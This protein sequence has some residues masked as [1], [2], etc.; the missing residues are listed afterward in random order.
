MVEIEIDV[1]KSLEENASEYF[2][3]AKKAKKK[4]EGA[5]KAY[6]LALKKKETLEKKRDEE[7]EKH[8]ESLKKE[9]IRK[10]EWYERFRWFFTSEGFLVIGGRDAT[11]NEIIIK[12]HTEKNDIV[13][14]TDMA[15]SPFFVIKADSAE[16]KEIGKQSLLE[17]ARATVTF[18]KAWKL[19]IR[20]TSVFY[21]N[22]KQ[23]TK[24]AQ[25]GEYLPKGAFMI[26]GKTEYIDND[27]DLAIGLFEGAFMAG[28]KTAVEKHCKEYI[29]LDVG[30]QKVSEV[31]KKIKQK[32]KGDLDEIIR[33]LPAGGF[34]IKKI[35]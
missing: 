13:F 25:S 29:I 15:G 10:K 26:R 30:N 12:K 9:V 31:A 6:L 32:F 16:E 27:I 5:R 33:V 20:T 17:A 1:R 7:L 35:L 14:H 21:V 24:E 2:D 8:E 4:I 11:T 34:E 19:G 23:V 18:S 28:P 3:K 22:P